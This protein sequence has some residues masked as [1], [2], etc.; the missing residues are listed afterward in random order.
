MRSP[1]DQKTF[2]EFYKNTVLGYSKGVLNHIC[3]R[4]E[5]VNRITFEAQRSLGD[6]DDIRYFENK[7]DLKKIISD[8]TED[9]R[10]AGFYEAWEFSK[11][12]KYSVPLFFETPDAKTIKDLLIQSNIQQFDETKYEPKMILNT[13]LKD[14]SPLFWENDGDIFLKFVLQKDYLIPDTFE[15]IDYRYPIVVY[16]NADNSVLEIR[17]DAMKYTGTSIITSDGYEQLVTDCIN[18]LRKTLK[19]EIYTCDHADIISVIN[20]KQNEEVKIYKQ[21]MELS[22][23]GSAELTASESADYVLPFIGEIRELIEEN[24][25]IFNQAE[26]IKNLL[27]QYLADKEAT[28]SY[29]YIYIKWVN[30]VESQSYIVKVTFDYL[31]RKYTLLQHITGSCKDL[32]MERMN[33]AIKYLCKTSS[34]V[35]GE[36][37]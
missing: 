25:E 28:A 22:T 35:K 24:E 37:I 14:S 8:T 15:R 10:F 5:I 17:Y 33:N 16:F 19:I 12:F 23:G 21:L 29:P 27:L 32:G 20:D 26:D 34:F 6:A 9:I 7:R 13:S 2:L 36:K 18:W 31:S 11:L 4:L 3:T 30:P 1:M